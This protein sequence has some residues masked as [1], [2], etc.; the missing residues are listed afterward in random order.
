ML[1]ARYFFAF[2]DK[3]SPL[4]GYA[5]LRFGWMSRQ[6][7]VDPTADVPLPGSHRQYPAFGVDGALPLVK[8]V[9]IE[10]QALYFINPMPGPDE[11]VG[12]G[13]S[14]TGSGFGFSAGLSGDVWGP[15]GYVLR[16]TYSSYQDEFSGAGNK[17]TNGGTAQETYAGLYWG[18]YAQF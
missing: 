12:Y 2:G 14:A 1:L 7:E 11:I 15:F 16:F 9:K 13:S 5:G 3:K 17:W 6:F 8:L 10:A 4:L 18:A